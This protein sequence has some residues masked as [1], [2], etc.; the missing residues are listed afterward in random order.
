MVDQSIYLP[1]TVRRA[2]YREARAQFPD[3]AC[4]ILLGQLELGRVRVNALRGATNS[5]SSDR[6]LQF[7]LSPYDIHCASQQARV[8]GW[9]IVGFFHSHPRGIARPSAQDWRD[10][11]PWPGYVHLIAALDE[12]I[13]NDLTA[14]RHQP[15]GWRQ[16]P[17]V[18]AR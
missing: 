16:Q 10:C 11:N 15:D 4:G 18:E 5:A 12:H 1:P 8:A 2:L 3:E 17:I 13:H 14:W 9:D 7:A 6:D